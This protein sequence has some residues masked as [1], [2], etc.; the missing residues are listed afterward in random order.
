MKKR[1]LLFS[2]MALLF[3][4]LSLQNAV[5]QTKAV[6]D[7]LYIFRNDGGFD[8]FFYGDIDR[9]C[10]SK[11]DTLG[12][13]Q[14]DFVVQ[15]VWALDSI[16][17]I[18]LSAID[19]VA[20][21]TPETIVWPDVFCPDDRIGDYI[22][23]SDSVWWIRLS[24]DTPPELLPKKDGKLLIEEGVSPLIPDGFGGRVGAVVHEDS[25]WLVITLPTDPADIYQRLVAKAAAA[26]P[27]ARRNAPSLDSDGT[28]STQVPERTIDFPS[29]STG[30]CK[31]SGNVIETPDGSPI[32]L[33]ANLTGTI[34]GSLNSGN[35][36]YRACLFFDPAGNKFEYDTKSILRFNA[37]TKLKAAGELKGRIELGMSKKIHKIDLIKLDIGAGLYLEGS[38]GGYEVSALVEEEGEIT[39]IAQCRDDNFWKTV[40]MGDLHSAMPV[41]KVDPKLTKTSITWENNL[42]DVEKDELILPN[43][44]S[45]SCGVF[46][47]AKFELAIPLSKMR[48]AMPD[49]VAMYIYQYAPA[50]LLDSVK[51]EFNLELDL[52]GKLSMKA[53]WAKFYEDV[54]LLGQDGS[55]YA[56]LDQNSE[57]TGEIHDNFKAVLNLGKWEPGYKPELS[58]PSRS[59]GLVPSIR[60]VGAEIDQEQHPVKPY[61]Y[62]FVAPITRD[63]LLPV[64]VGFVVF[65]EYDRIEA[66]YSDIPWLGESSLEKDPGHQWFKNGTYF[67]TI[68]IDPAKGESRSFYAHPIVR[69]VNGNEVL[70]DSYTE[71]FVDSAQ[72]NIP[73]RTVFV[74]P[75]GGMVQGE[76]TDEK[77]V[78]V[79][80]NMENVQVS[81]KTDWID[82]LYWHGEDNKVGFHWKDLPQLPQGE[83]Q[84][85]GTIYLTGL[86]KRGEVLVVD[87]I[88]V[89]QAAPYIIVEPKKMVFPIEGGT[90]VATIIET[91]VSNITPTISP[92]NYI[93]E[94][95]VSIN[96]NT[97]TVT[98]NDNSDGDSRSA[99]V[100]LEGTGPDGLPVK[101]YAIE[102][103]Q[104]GTGEDPG[105]DPWESYEPISKRMLQI[106]DLDYKVATSYN[107]TNGLYQWTW[108]DAYMGYSDVRDDD[109]DGT[110]RYYEEVT[111]DGNNLHVKQVQQHVYLENGVATGGYRNDTLMFDILDYKN[112]AVGLPQIANVKHISER[113]DDNG[114]RRTWE[115]EMTDIP[116][117]E[118]KEVD[119]GA[120]R[121]GYPKQVT[122]V[123]DA[124]AAMGARVVGGTSDWYTTYNG[125]PRHIHWDLI[126][127]YP[128]FEIEFELKFMGEVGGYYVWYDEWQ[129]YFPEGFD[130]NSLLS[131]DSSHDS[132]NPDN[133]NRDKAKMIDKMKAWDTLLMQKKEKKSS[134]PRD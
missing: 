27:G 45:I 30:E 79:I 50:L 132:E 76:Y 48:K 78:E 74:G 32:S 58:V 46:A 120:Y 6:Q 3:S 124:N 82:R 90:Q 13:E 10:Y 72:F 35:M 70:V 57:F 33:A 129:Y 49:W 8:F 41:V 108:N 122:L 36:T 77:Y 47:K 26:T 11:I 17:R 111:E 16:F 99:W 51:V 95:R 39:S 65:D 21:V 42:I 52:G 28:Y 93:G 89:I 23:A 117:S 81:T 59:L 55:L 103:T 112:L 25:G 110:Y 133:L 18:P 121:P 101:S 131:S 109:E 115:V 56:D 71:F 12:V 113:V 102:I 73:Q 24:H 118:I 19:S 123:V 40:L 75:E 106:T 64:N 130:P 53:P 98:A 68:S 126:P 9:I 63:L 125:N 105:T 134:K 87:S 67:R 20:F 116:I 7:A 15:E 2:L 29:F 1:H 86:S 127:N 83:N 38:I 107:E 4:L 84:R 114:D 14:P 61:L 85:R 66:K 60:G 100:V 54:P 69:L 88:T 34:E 119:V 44:A 62:R 128:D 91:S 22:I 43:S 31:F 104:E 97:I 37:S 80:P 96:G 92:N 5:A 94:I